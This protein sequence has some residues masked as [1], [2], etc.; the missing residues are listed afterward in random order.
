MAR[1]WVEFPCDAG[2]GQVRVVRTALERMGYTVA[3]LRGAGPVLLRLAG[4]QLE[5]AELLRGPGGL[6]QQRGRGW[7]WRVVSEYH[8]SL[9]LSPAPVGTRGASVAG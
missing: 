5:A 6:D 7:G 1:A 4:G 8:I 2:W 3:E 9:P